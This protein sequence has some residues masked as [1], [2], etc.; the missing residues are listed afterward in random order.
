MAK[1]VIDVSYANTVTDWNAVAREVDGVVIRIGYRGYNIGVIKADV[2][3]HKHI[4]GALGAGIPVGFYFMSQAVSEAEASAEAKYC[5]DCISNYSMMLPQGDD[6]Q[7]YYDSELSNSKGTGRADKLTKQ[8]R[9][10]ICNA[11]CRRVEE[12]GYR[13]G[14]YASTSWYRTHLDVSALTGYLLWV[15]QYNKTCTA[16][17]RIDLWQH[18]SSGRIAG[19]SGDVD[20]SE[21]YIAFG[22]GSGSATLTPASKVTGYDCPYAEPGCTLYQGRHGMAAEHVRWLQWQLVRLGYLTAKNEAGQDNI[23]GVFGRRTAAAVYGF[24]SEH[25]ETYTTDT[26]DCRIGPKSREV[27][28]R[29]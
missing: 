22:E 8:Q 10:A 25:P 17:H 14:V 24:Q 27:L 11:F 1:K 9:T 29:L 7:I 6:I 26:P 5:A 3:F 28:K 16:S 15:A 18:T 12:L 21:C 20:V 4:Q 2:N 13:A 23:D 19:I